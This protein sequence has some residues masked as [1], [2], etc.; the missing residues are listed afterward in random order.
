MKWFHNIETLKELRHLYRILLKKYHPDTGHGDSAITQEINEEYDTLFALLSQK[1]GK[2]PA[3]EAEHEA[4]FKETLQKIIGLNIRIEVIGN[5]I[6]CFDCFNEKETLKELGF[7][8]ASKKKAWIWHAAPYKRRYQK[9]IPLDQI[10]QKYG[11]RTV[12]YREK[13]AALEE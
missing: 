10:R 9:E 3:S 11:A 13:P 4:A 7:T 6:W 1:E 12:R 5:W 2:D 8:W